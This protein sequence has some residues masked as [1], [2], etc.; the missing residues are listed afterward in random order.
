MPQTSEVVHDWN[1]LL[2]LEQV[3]LVHV[4][5]PAT[6]LQA[7]FHHAI[8]ARGGGWQGMFEIG[9]VVSTRYTS[10]DWRVVRVRLSQ[11]RPASPTEEAPGYWH[12]G[13]AAV[14]QPTFVPAEGSGSDV[15]VRA[16]TKRRKPGALLLVL[17]GTLERTTRFPFRRRR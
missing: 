11:P 9:P 14:H 16:V 7:R 10:A 13:S 8:N 1:Q 6:Q 3:T 2:P 4:A 5:N 17:S 12:N 15:D